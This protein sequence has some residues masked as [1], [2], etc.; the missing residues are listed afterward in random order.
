M[1]PSNPIAGLPSDGV[2]FSFFTPRSGN[3]AVNT[4]SLWGKH[5]SPHQEAP[6][7]IGRYNIANGSPYKPGQVTPE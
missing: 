5:F 2:N 1:L 3:W 6:V 7:F 4:A